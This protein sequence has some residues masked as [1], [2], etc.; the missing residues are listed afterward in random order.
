MPGADDF[1]NSRE[2]DGNRVILLPPADVCK[3]CFCAED[4]QLVQFDVDSCT[5]GG[6]PQNREAGQ[7]QKVW[8]RAALG[9]WKVIKK[10]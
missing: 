5:S 7:N 3:D 4:W 1:R 6:T 9:P 2:I 8:L 10:S